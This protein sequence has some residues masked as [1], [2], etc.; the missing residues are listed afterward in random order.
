MIEQLMDRPS[1][2]HFPDSS[3]EGGRFQPYPW[4]QNG[5]DDI[6]RLIKAF[7]WMAGVLE[8]KQEKLVHS[9]MI[10]AIGTFGAGVT[11][12]LNKIQLTTATLRR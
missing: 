9:R 3:R 11:H 8:S 1:S 5:N 4:E 6:S 12:E 10:A 7:N 2:A